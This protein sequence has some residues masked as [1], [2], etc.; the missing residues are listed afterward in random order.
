MKLSMKEEL[1]ELKKH[2]EFALKSKG[3]KDDVLAHVSNAYIK[4]N[5]VLH[6]MKRGKIEL[7]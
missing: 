6:D 4:L 5:D 3:K 1:E 7:K 2:L